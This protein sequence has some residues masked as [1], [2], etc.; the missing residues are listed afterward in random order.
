MMTKFGLASICGYQTVWG[1][2]PALHSPLMSVTNAI[3]GLTAVGGMVLAGGGFVPGSVAQ[4]LAGL[5]VLVSA[6]N[7]GGGFTITQ[8]RGLWCCGGAEGVGAGA[9]GEAVPLSLCA[10]GT[11]AGGGG[12]GRHVKRA[13]GA[14]LRVR[15]RARPAPCASRPAPPRPPRPPRGPGAAH[16]VPR[17]AG[18]NRGA[19]HIPPAAADVGHVQAPHRPARVQR[20][21]QQRLLRGACCRGASS[22]QG[23][24]QSL[25]S[26][27]AAPP[28]PRPLLPAGLY[29]LSAAALL[30]AYGAGHWA[31]YT[32]MEVR[33]TGVVV[34]GVW[35]RCGC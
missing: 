9:G 13:C 28:L 2:T 15:G 25:S 20:C 6:V 11:T 26:S 7:I 21:A 32:E 8:V 5:A 3:S 22:V 23:N 30:S 12:G 27:A 24:G 34:L 33:G 35:C 17:E 31:G 14:G 10:A 29:A 16:E 18:A 19:R 1:V 4:G